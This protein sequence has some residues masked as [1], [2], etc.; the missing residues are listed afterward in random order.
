[1]SSVAVCVIIVGVG[2]IGSSLLQDLVRF[3]P[4][5]IDI[6][7][8]DGDVA[9]GKNLQRQ[10]FC[11]KH[12]GQNKAEALQE[13]A[14]AA[15]GFDRIYAHPEFLDDTQQIHTVARYY[16]RVIL[17]GC[18]DNHPARRVMERFV[19]ETNRATYYV[20]CANAEH[21]GEVMAVC[22]EDGVIRGQFR[23][24][25]DDTVLTDESGDPTKKSCNQQLDE[26][27]VQTLVANRKAAITALELISGCMAGQPE[28]GTIFF[29][30]CR[31]ERTAPVLQVA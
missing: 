17:V 6:H 28:V 20:D 22:R 2:G 4:H 3:L 10:H 15:L 11:K 1:M 27:N 31:I 23:S 8:F 18:V 30:K 14:T 16:Q 5:M 25:I 12:L 9:E 24:E 19:Q 21:G 7:L 13:V 29:N 26:G